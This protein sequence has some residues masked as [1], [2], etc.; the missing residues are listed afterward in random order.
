MKE[1][2][3][4][5]N[6]NHWT[7]TGFYPYTSSVICR[8]FAQSHNYKVEEHDF[9]DTLGA[10]VKQMAEDKGCSWDN[11]VVV[12]ITYSYKD[13]EVLLNYTLVGMIVDGVWALVFPK[14]IGLKTE[15]NIF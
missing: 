11:K 13:A 4:M 12:E 14:M 1:F 3:F 10:S 7:V 2:F 6:I 8:L 15:I 5:F 9:L